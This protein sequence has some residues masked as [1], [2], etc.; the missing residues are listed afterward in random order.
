MFILVRIRAAWA[1]RHVVQ[2]VAQTFAPV[3]FD[4]NTSVSGIQNFEYESSSPNLE[5]EWAAS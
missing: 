2:L 5:L 4:V 1:P 3:T